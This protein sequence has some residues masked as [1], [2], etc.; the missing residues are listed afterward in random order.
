MKTKEELKKSIYER[1]DYYSDRF[2]EDGPCG[3]KVNGCKDDSCTNRKRHFTDKNLYHNYAEFYSNIISDLAADK[4]EFSLLELGTSRGGSVAAW[5]EAMPHAFVCGVDK[6]ESLLWIDKTQYKN[7][8]ILEG[9]HGD[10]ST[11]TPISDKKFN[12]IIDDGSHMATEQQQNFYVLQDLIGDGGVYVI[13]DV[14][15]TNTYD[16]SFLKKFELLDFSPIT[17]RFDDRVLVFRKP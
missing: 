4:E 2:K 16:P 13:E 8:V 11:Y 3:A 1:L 5:C 10:R 9:L 15:P 12:I 7:L 17:G 6:D 14:Y